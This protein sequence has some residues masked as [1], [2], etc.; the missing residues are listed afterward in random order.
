MNV[1]RPQTKFTCR[2]TYA[3]VHID[4]FS[5]CVHN[6]YRSKTSDKDDSANQSLSIC[7]L[8][9]RH[10]LYLPQSADCQLIDKS[11][12][13]LVSSYYAW[14]YRYIKWR[15]IIHRQ[16]QIHVYTYIH[17]VVHIF[18][19]CAYLEQIVSKQLRTQ[20]EF[21]FQRRQKNINSVHAIDEEPIARSLHSISSRFSQ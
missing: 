1:L 5:Y 6:I 11:L 7:G 17:S 4:L 19:V 16:N 9:V 13:T 3:F 18:Y 20:F 12:K 2:L 14:L 8:R 15:D 10:D 21:S